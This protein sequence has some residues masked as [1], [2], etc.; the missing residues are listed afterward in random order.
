[1]AMLNNQRVRYIKTMVM[2][3]GFPPRTWW[4]SYIKI[5]LLK[6]LK[7]TP[8]RM[9]NMDFKP[10]KWAA[11][12]LQMT[13]MT[14]PQMMSSGMHMEGVQAK[15]GSSPTKQC[16]IF[17]NTF[18]YRQTKSKETP[19]DLETWCFQWEFHESTFAGDWFQRSSG[20]LWFPPHLGW[21]SSKFYILCS[22]Y[23]LGIDGLATSQQPTSGLPPPGFRDGWWFEMWVATQKWMVWRG[24]TGQLCKGFQAVQEVIH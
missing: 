6:L 7:L 4:S 24:S 10:P 8:R 2:N 19:P 13:H 3:G 14:Q 9:K 17:Q 1:M 22:Y 23:F 5:W 15:K 12:F 21:R 20:F 18:D 16:D 11:H